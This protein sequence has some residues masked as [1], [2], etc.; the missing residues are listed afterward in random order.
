MAVLNEKNNWVVSGAKRNGWIADQGRK[1]GPNQRSDG[2]QQNGSNISNDASAI[3]DLI[4]WSNCHPEPDQEGNDQT[5]ER[6]KEKEGQDPV[7]DDEKLDEGRNI[8]H[9]LN[10]EMNSLLGSSTE[11]GML[12]STWATIMGDH[13]K[14]RIKSVQRSLIWISARKHTSKKTRR[15]LARYC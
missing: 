10:E 14:A 13:E 11:K 8:V 2:H 12:Q 1:G 7:K 4:E 5:D 6:Q 3:T 9:E 15:G